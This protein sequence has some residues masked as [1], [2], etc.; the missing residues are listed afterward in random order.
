MSEK[1]PC[2]ITDGVQYEDLDWMQ[3]DDLTEDEDAAYE[4]WRQEQIDSDES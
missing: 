2:S 1:M 4:R 3:V